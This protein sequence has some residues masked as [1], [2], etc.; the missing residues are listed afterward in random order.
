MKREF[1]RVE[2][3]LLSPEEGGRQT[4][5]VQEA[6]H[7]HYR[8]HIVI[9][10]PAQREPILVERD[11]V[12]NYIDEDYLGVA[13]WEGPNKE[14]LPTNEPMQLLMVLSYFPDVNYEMVIPGATY[15][16]REGGR[17]IGYGEIKERWGEEV[18]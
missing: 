1:I 11:G 6:F 3:T 14:I 10:D 17:I 15:T 5:I 16:L 8:P 4:P 13:F 18:A 2:L 12:K 7:G 9:G